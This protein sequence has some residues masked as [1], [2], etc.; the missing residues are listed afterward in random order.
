MTRSVEG[1]ALGRFDDGAGAF[2]G[3]A[4]GDRVL[5]LADDSLVKGPATYL[6]LLEDWATVS[7]AL[8]RL[9]AQA[10]PGDGLPIGDLEVLAPVE[11]RQI[12]QA[13][14]NYRSHVAQIIVSGREPDDLR[15][16]EEL[17]QAAEQVMDEK[18]RR[19]NPFVFAGLPTA[20]CGPD[21]DV[22]LPP[23]SSQIDWET[24][25]AVVIGARAHRVPAQRA[26]DHVAGYTVCND[27]S[28][29]DLQFTPENRVL[30]GDWIRAK[31]RPTFLPTGPFLV[32]A[33][34][35]PDHRQLRI[36]FDLNGERMQDD[37]PAS[38]LF[39]VPSLIAAVSAATTLLPGD[40]LLT[41]SP[42]GNGGHW[43]RWLQ[44]GDVMEAAI[45]GLGGHRNR[46][47]PEVV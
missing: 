34:Q 46:C 43:R 26:M 23:E 33:E 38:M 24:E 19:G 7:A 31:N 10:G 4:V 37:V 45:A 8:P 22:L 41:G 39:D 35:I 29:R 36:T 1:H 6:A 44:P 15:S 42:A 47:V 40:L 18:V 32:P 21:H 2:T 25:L 3:L 12:F 11:P 17:R 13:G 14:A 28:A 9:A 5:R 20:I 30:G 16:D 27:V